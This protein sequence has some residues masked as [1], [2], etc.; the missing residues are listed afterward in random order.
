[1]NEVDCCWI[2]C[3]PIFVAYSFLNSHDDFVWYSCSG[4]TINDYYSHYSVIIKL[5]MQTQLYLY[6]K[7]NTNSLTKKKIG[8]TCSI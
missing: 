3:K 1:M 6:V 5:V 2:M 8:H 4:F 7:I